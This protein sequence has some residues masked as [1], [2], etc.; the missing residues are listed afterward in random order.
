MAKSSALSMLS[1]INAVLDFSTMEAGKL[2]LEMIS[3]SL[4]SSI[5]TMLKSLGMR[6][7]QKGIELTADI[8]AVVPDHVIGDPMRLQQILTNLIDNA[9][10]FT[11][12]GDVMLRVEVESETDARHCLHFDAFTQ[13]DSISTHAYGGSGLGL[14][15]ASHLVHKMGGRIW[16]DSIVGKGTTFHFTVQLAVQQTPR[17]RGSARQFQHA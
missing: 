5:G 3:F 2:E 9:I 14:A 13:A 1:V 15:I 6:A 17:T 11:K 7:D 10:K 16:L 12:S 8:P 4:R